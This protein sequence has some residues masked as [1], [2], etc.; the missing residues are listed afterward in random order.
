MA[1][2]S[3]RFPH[4]FQEMAESIITRLR[5]TT[6]IDESTEQIINDFVSHYMDRDRALEDYASLNAAGAQGFYDALVDVSKTTN[7]T[8][9]VF[10]GIGEAINY[11]DGV[12][13]ANASMRIAVRRVPSVTLNQYVETANISAIGRTVVLIGLSENKEATISNQGESANPRWDLNNKTVTI[14]TLLM[15]NMGI[16]NT[17]GSTYFPSVG[18]M[19]VRQ[20]F[21]TS[22]QAIAVTNSFWADQ[23]DIQTGGDFR[24]AVVTLTNCSV[25]TL[26]SISV[27]VPG[28]SWFWYD[29]WMGNTSAA[30][31]LTFSTSMFVLF[32]NCR[33]RYASGAAVW[34]N[35]VF[36][37]GATLVAHG[38]TLNGITLPDPLSV[39]MEGCSAVLTRTNTT[40]NATRFCIF[41][42]IIGGVVSIAG[43]AVL[44]LTGSFNTVTLTGDDIKA[45]I[46]GQ[47]GL[48]ASPTIIL[49]SV[50]N[51]YVEACTVFSSPP[52]TL[53]T[54]LFLD[55]GCANVL[56]D[57]TGE[58]TYPKSFVN[59]GTNCLVRTTAGV[60]PSGTAGGDLTGSYPNPQVGSLS[61][62]TTAGDLAVGPLGLRL[63]VGAA[64]SI[65]VPDSTQPGGL[66]W[67]LVMPSRGDLVAGSATGAPVKV[68]V[69]LDA[70]ELRADS[71]Q[72]AGVSWGYE[73]S[74]RNG[75]SINQASLETD[76][77]GWAAESGCTIARNAS[78]ASHGTASLEV[79]KS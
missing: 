19:W 18:S 65:L 22:G 56:V 3:F 75:L 53:E 68:A 51:S 6:G 2:G 28:A 44:D 74:L 63:P 12:L 1:L 31:T 60:P 47:G 76:T 36:G 13:A 32:D 9:R 15:S 30:D 45:S 14:P 61:F 24:A 33:G 58:R 72:A 7:T 38:S 57:L 35:L 39:T 70:R 49:N 10:A 23:T 17:G 66:R 67:D 79:T 71:S 55:P 50:T 48:T 4:E 73:R 41:R 34:P 27:G 16:T 21:F 37:T 69:G 77:T 64:G 54:P 26:G 5:E 8:N 43:P 11:L 40:L 78:N 62:L 25:R 29:T 52:G 59:S 20:C 46:S 42:G